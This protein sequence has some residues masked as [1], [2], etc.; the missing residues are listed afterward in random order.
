MR[1]LKSRLSRDTRSGL[2][3]LGGIVDENIYENDFVRVWFDDELMT[4]ARN[5]NL[6]TLTYKG[7]ITMSP[8]DELPLAA[9]FL[10]NYTVKYNV[11]DQ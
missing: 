8:E 2:M 7:E 4:L 6:W 1:E 10:L 3:R 9:R 11:V 5:G